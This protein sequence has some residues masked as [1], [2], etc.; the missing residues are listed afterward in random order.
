M[1]LFDFKD[2]IVVVTGGSRGIG[3]AIALAFGEAGAKVVVAA[4]KIDL[5]KEVV[6]DIKAKGG[7]GFY[8]KCD[9]GRDEDIYNLVEQTLNKYNGL[10]ILV[11]NAGI[12]PFVK[13]SEEVTKEMWEEVIQVN[14]LAPFLLCREA[15]KIMMKQNWGRIINIASVGGI[16]A[17][18]RQIAY[19]AT[20]GALIQMTKVLAIEWA[21]KYNITVNAIAPG[22]ITTELTAGMRASEK[23]SK[24]LL[25]RNPAGRFGEAD[26]VVSAALYFASESASFTTGAVLVVDGGMLAS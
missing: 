21:A 6:N 5:L 25:Q 3:R 19:C 1:R 8:V 10:D 11:N 23:I 9:L 14:L 26:E 17:L 4:R 13:K 16:I 7:D 24:N 22:Y 15:A 2:K 20:K 18:P 12:S